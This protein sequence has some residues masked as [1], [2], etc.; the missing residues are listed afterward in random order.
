MPD[1]VLLADAALL[2]GFLGVVAALLL[3]G[4]ADVFDAGFDTSFFSAGA[5]PDEAEA[6]PPA[7]V[8]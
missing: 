5:W 8:C 3:P 1:F 7:L 4:F 6:F 2:A